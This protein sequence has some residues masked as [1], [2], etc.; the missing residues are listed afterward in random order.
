MNDLSPNAIFLS[1]AFEPSSEELRAFARSEKE[2][3][4]P[5]QDRKQPSP[6]P[7]KSKPPALRR[8]PSTEL[9]ELSSD[10]EMPDVSEILSGT[11]KEGGHKLPTHAQSGQLKR[12][13]GKARAKVPVDVWMFSA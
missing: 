9:I 8:P 4:R 11:K 2:R 3:S 12:L 1:S 7:P 6:V 5:V 10:E 13:L